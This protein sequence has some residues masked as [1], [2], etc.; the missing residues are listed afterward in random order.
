MDKSI[1]FK[2]TGLKSGLAE[3]VGLLHLYDDVLTLEFETKDT[4]IGTILSSVHEIKVSLTDI[5]SIENRKKIF[6]AKIRLKAFKMKTFKG[7]P[8]HK[9]GQ[10]ELEF[11]RKEKELAHD[12][13][14]L[15]SH[16]LKMLSI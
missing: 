8:G 1:P 9:Q 11:G 2:V 13:S 16:K 14:K 7:F 3:A 5:E 6:G 4:V 10:I 12:L 15:M